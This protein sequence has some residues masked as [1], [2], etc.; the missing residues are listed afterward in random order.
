MNYM[1]EIFLSYKKQPLQKKMI[2][3]NMNYKNKIFLPY[4]KQVFF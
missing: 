1:N 2:F 4:K 3:F